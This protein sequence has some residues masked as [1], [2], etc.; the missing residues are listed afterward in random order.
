MKKDSTAELIEIMF[1]ISRL[2]KGSMS[3]TNDFTHLSV[4][5]IQTLVYL[6][7]NPKTSMSDIAQYFHIELPSATSLINKLCDQ[8]LIKR[9][10]DPEDRRLVM[11][12][13]TTTGKSLLE[14]AL[15]ERKIKLEKILSYLSATQKTELL[16]IMETL[17]NRLQQ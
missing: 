11:L 14:H 16:T 17:Q 3:Y 7:Q 5:Q 13:L 12:A 1:K 4:M 15:H 2:L 10:E 8:D 9:S 6:C